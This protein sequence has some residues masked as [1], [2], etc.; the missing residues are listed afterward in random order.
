MATPKQET[1]YPTP[2]VL[3]KYFNQTPTYVQNAVAQY[4]Q[5]LM[6]ATQSVAHSS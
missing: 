2:Q 6:N 5:I 1:N 3:Q 4:N